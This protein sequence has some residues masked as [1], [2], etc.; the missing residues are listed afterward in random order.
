M[1]YTNS[2]ILFDEYSKWNYQN[3]FNQIVQS[4]IIK[5]SSIVSLKS[6]YLINHNIQL[7]N[8][9][10]WPRAN[11]LDKTIDISN[12]QISQIIANYT[13]FINFKNETSFKEMKKKKNI[14]WLISLS[15][16]ELEA[17]F[18][19]RL[20]KFH[21]TP[22]IAMILLMFTEKNKFLDLKQICN[23][24]ICSK[25]SIEIALEDLVITNVYIFI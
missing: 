9:D 8:S 12:E 5:S 15:T 23:K 14:K 24:I 22:L 25:K 16:F 19:N 11:N 1:E 6:D 13:E 2:N 7:I 21:T 4:N 20:Y 3:K 10:C 18:G 17:N